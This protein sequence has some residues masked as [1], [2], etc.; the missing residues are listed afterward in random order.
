LLN[1]RLLIAALTCSTAVGDVGVPAI[2]G[3][4]NDPFW[5]RRARVWYLSHPRIPENGVTFYL[6]FDEEHLYLAADVTD[7]NIFGHHHQRKD[8]TWKDDAVTF[9]LDFGDGTARD[10]TPST[11]SY[12]FSAAGGVS[13]TRGVA[14]GSGENYPGHDWLPNWMSRLEWATRLKPGSTI[15][16][17]PDHDRG[18]VVEARIPWTE[19]GTVPPFAPDRRIG[20]CLL[21]ICRPEQDE[22]NQGL[23]I[24]SMPGIDS[25]NQHAPYLWQRVRMDWSAASRSGSLVRTDRLDALARAQYAPAWPSAGRQQEQTS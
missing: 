9:L 8:E 15:N 2:D 1:A 20:V 17:E 25:S 23:P 10:R 13:W 12:E 5:S 11:F 18:Y 14:D 16:I 6:G 3:F 7:A 21:N 19:L 22:S 4:L 24:T